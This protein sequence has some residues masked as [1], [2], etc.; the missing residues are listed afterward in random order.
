MIRI[1][2]VAVIAISYSMHA[3]AEAASER[4]MIAEK[5]VLSWR[6][7]EC[8]VLAEKKG[9]IAEQERLFRLGYDEGMIFLRA[10]DAGKLN[11]ETLRAH[12]AWR[13]TFRLGGP[14]HDFRLGRIF[15]AAADEVYGQVFTGTDEE[16]QRL[17]ASNEF[18]R[19]NCSLL[20]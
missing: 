17:E 2:V 10:L 8:S 12:A 14:S 15:E 6:A 5:S 3:L 11:R 4:T 20:R 13:F 9:D 7:F 18:T 1:F 19:R 16:L